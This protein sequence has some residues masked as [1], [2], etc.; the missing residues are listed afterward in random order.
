MKDTEAPQGLAK[1]QPCQ[2]AHREGRWKP[3]PW[4]ATCLETGIHLPQA[5]GLHLKLGGI[6]L[7][8]QH[9]IDVLWQTNRVFALNYFIISLGNVT[10]I[11]NACKLYTLKIY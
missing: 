7:V 2:Q 5:G 8:S 4:G 9:H 3:G 10:H 11:K 1:L 6:A